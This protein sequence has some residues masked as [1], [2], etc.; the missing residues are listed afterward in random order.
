[1]GYLLK[2]DRYFLKGEIFCFY[3]ML[4][5]IL[6]EIGIEKYDFLSGRFRGWEDG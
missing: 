5:R 4:L 1:M 3:Y 6:V 2:V